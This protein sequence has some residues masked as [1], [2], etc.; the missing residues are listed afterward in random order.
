M[1]GTGADSPAD[2]DDS[3]DE[4]FRKIE[5]LEGTVD[6]EAE[7]EE[8]EE[9]RRTLERVPGGQFVRSRIDRYTTRDVAEGFVGSI[10]FSLPLLVEDGVFDIADHLLGTTVGPVPVWLV[11]NIVFIAVM[12]WGLLYWTEFREVR[13]PN[14][15]FGVIPRRV[16]GVLVIS[17]L[18]ATLTMT[19]W[20]RLGGWENPA[21]AVA[22]VSVVWA[23]AA[24]GA[25][26]G[27]IL[28][29]ESSGTDLDDVSGEVRERI[30]PEQT[31]DE[32]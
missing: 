32:R 25:V 10:L 11:V 19:M 2:R 15:W 6:S 30:A 8:V 1:T 20:G 31:E 29:G 24:L 23:A 18:T 21:V 13:D 4:V 7:R 9:V 26:L 3:L 17:L 16:V 28:P 27:D 5:K 12:T 14:P 22:R